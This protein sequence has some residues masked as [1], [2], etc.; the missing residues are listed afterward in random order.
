MM[1]EAGKTLKTSKKFFS[2]ISPTA[3][4]MLRLGWFGACQSKYYRQ[5]AAIIGEN[6]FSDNGNEVAWGTIGNASASEGHFFEAINAAGVLQV[7]MVISVWDDGV[8]NSVPAKYQTTKENISE[9]LKGF[10]RD[11]KGKALRSLW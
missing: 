10:Q 6:A 1:T 5:Q 8:R 7:P 2:D 11:E 9:I 4:Q 3:G